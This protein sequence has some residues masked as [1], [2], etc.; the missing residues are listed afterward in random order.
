[1]IVAIT[2][3]QFSRLVDALGIR[4]E[5]T[6]LEISNGGPMDDQ[7]ALFDA[8]NELA[9]LMRGWFAERSFEETTTVLD[10]HNVLWG[11]YQDVQELVEGDGRWS[12]ASA[13]FSEVDQPGVGT[14][15]MPGS[16]LRFE[17]AGRLQ[18]V[19]A[20][21]LGEHTSEVLEEVLGLGSREI[22]RLHDRGVVA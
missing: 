22:G 4:E 21:L 10:I 19:R 8:R 7:A 15:P 2:P 18:P 9:N 1:M 14:Y 16:P 3:G 12:I 6:R 11:P 13:G 20:P 17:E 5:I